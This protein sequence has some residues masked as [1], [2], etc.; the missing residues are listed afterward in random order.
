M[1]LYLLLGAKKSS[2]TQPAKER[3]VEAVPDQK[4]SLQKNK[5]NM[6]LILK[7]LIESII[8][9]VSH[10]YIGKYNHNN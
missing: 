6:T 3:I 10:A 1:K 7:Y 8:L 5:K 4:N 9:Q 2:V